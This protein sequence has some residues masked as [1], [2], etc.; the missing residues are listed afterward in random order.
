MESTPFFTIFTPVYNGEASITRVFD[1]IKSQ[2]FKDFEWIV[3]N[4][5]SKD[6]TAEVIQGFIRSNPQLDIKYVEQ[7]NSGKHIAWN[8]GVMLA[9]GKL[10][11]PADADDAFLPETLSFYYQKWSSLSPREQADISGINVLC[12]DN[13]SGNIVGDVYPEDGMKSTNLELSYK[14]KLKGEKWGCI[15][16]D[17][18]KER[19]FPIIRGYV[20]EN[21]VWFQLSKHYKILCFNKPL[22]KYYT[23]VTGITQTLE[24]N[25][26]DEL[27][28]KV[29]L[30]YNLW[31]ISNFGGYVLLHAPKVFVRTALSIAVRSFLLLR[32]NKLFA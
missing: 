7:S 28:T 31:F 8:K 32:Y 2:E 13:D 9:R 27:K 30:K 3:V 6:N 11:V 14:Y 16:T 22:R 29:R 5:G 4:D 12:L 1:S 24:D 10:F 26:F 18:L 25:K 20:T 23:T 21:Y 17:L 15:R 19:P